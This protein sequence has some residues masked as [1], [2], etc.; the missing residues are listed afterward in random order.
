MSAAYFC[1]ISFPC[2]SGARVTFHILF[3]WL[4]VTILSAALVVAV[5]ALHF[6]FYSPPLEGC[7]RYISHFIPLL[8]RGARQGGVVALS[9]SGIL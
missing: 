1:H 5:P 9:R 8:W 4:R 7:P 6:T 2:C 3:L